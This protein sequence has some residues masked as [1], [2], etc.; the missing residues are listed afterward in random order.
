MVGRKVSQVRNHVARRGF[1]L[2]ELLV[3][4]A[5]IG[6]LVAL[7]LPAVQAAR[8]AARRTQCSNNLR[9]M[10]LALHNYVS[11]R[12]ELPIAYGRKLEHVVGPPVVN[13]LKDGLFTR[14]LPYSEEQAAYD[15][16]DFLY[17]KAGRQYTDDPAKNI[18]IPMFV[19]PVWPDGPVNFV[20]QPGFEYSLGALVTYS[21]VGGAVRN[22]GEKLIPSGFGRVPDNGACLLAQELVHGRFPV[23]VGRARKV[24]QIKDGLSKS[25]LIGEF[26]HRNCAL[27][28]FTEP[29]PGNVRPWYLAGFGDAPYQF[30]VLEN[31]PNVCISR[32][33]THFNYL[34]MGS[35]HDGITQFVHC[36]GSV[37]VIP[38]EVDLEVYKD[39]AT[40]NGNEVI[41]ADY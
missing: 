28:Q 26:V 29:S 25:F 20:A 27:G 16:V 12:N 19:C 13:F 18:V 35:F 7:L 8:E 17:Y 14:L 41:R 6:V 1:T 38:D 11:A 31:P 4:I 30:K 40:V 33:D 23:A 32:N 34:P 36:D 22:R 2:V 3:V 37:H 21:G 24:R 15:R 39:F 10:G 9:Q 5:I